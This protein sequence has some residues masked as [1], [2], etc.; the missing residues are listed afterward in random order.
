M[1]TIKKLKD[2]QLRIG[3]DDG[4]TVTAKDWNDAMTAILE[5]VNTNADAVNTTLA[6]PIAVTIH[7]DN[8]SK[9]YKWFRGAASRDYHCTFM[10][11]ILNKQGVVSAHFYNTQG[12]EVSCNYLQDDERVTV[13]SRVNAEILAIFR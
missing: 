12:T 3:F 9:E 6:T 13:Y 8:T 7:P 2:S 4:N 5:A 11:S 10:K 1:A